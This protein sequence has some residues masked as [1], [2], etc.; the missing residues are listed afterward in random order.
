MAAQYGTNTTLDTLK[1]LR[2]TT[3]ANYGE[4]RA[5]AAVTDLLDAHNAIMREMVSSLCDFTADQLNSYGGAAN[6][7]MTE[8]DEFG[9]PDVQKL[10]Q[11]V[12][13]GFPL[14]LFQYGIGWTRKYLQNR[15]VAEWAA[16]LEGAMIAHALVVE[17]Q[18]KKAIFTPT[19]NLTYKDKLTNG[20]TLPLRALLN[21][22]STEIPPD[23]W[24]NA[25]TA[26]THTHYIGTGSFVA[27]N[28]TSLIAAVREHYNTGMI[29]VDINQAQEA[30]IRAFSGFQA[31]VDS[32]IV[33]SQTSTYAVGGLDIMNIYNRSIGIFDGAEIHVKPWIPSAYVFA[34]NIMQNKPLKFRTRDGSWS[35]LQL[36]A[37]L[38]Q[39]P[40]YAKVF[41]DEFG[42][43]V[44][45][46]ANGAALKTDNATY[47]TPTGL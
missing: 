47:S 14:R 8:A 46:R 17:S 6:G 34:Y 20:V 21:A 29:Q 15:T 43:S 26:S 42:I 41:E 38:A 12:D 2:N 19:N 10:S 13:V 7:T 39:Y 30:A 36:A 31:L 3:V 33:Q 25:F 45:E 24:G 11:G 28:L 22:D 44:Y 9:A 27:A 23:P 40:L 18:I 37:D 1:A 5:Y 35:G 4:D 16:Q 32:R